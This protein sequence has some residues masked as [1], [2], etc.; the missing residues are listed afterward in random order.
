M[1]K[2]RINNNHNRKDKPMPMSMANPMPTLN[3]RSFLQATT[4][5]AMLPFF[6]AG[7]MVLAQDAASIIIRAE[8]DL[9]S[10]DPANPVGVIDGVIIKAVCQ[11][12]ATFKPN[13]LDYEPDAAKSLTQVSDTEIAFELNPG[14]M[15]SGGY[16][17]MTAEDVKFSLERYITPAADG[18]LPTAAGDFSAIDHVE[19]TGTYTGRI[20]L[21]NAAP[22]LW[23]VGLCD[24]GGAILSRKAVEALGKDIAT[25]IVGTGPYELTDWQPGQQIVLDQRADFAGIAKGA[26]Q[27]IV[28]KPIVETRTALLSLLAGEI[29][30]TEVA[31]QDEA[32]LMSS[33]SVVAVKSS[34]IDYTWIGMNVEKPALSD[35][36]VREALRLGID[37]DTLL[38]GA[39]GGAE[40]RANALLAPGLIGHWADAPVHARDLDKARALLAE[41]GQSALTITFTY[42]K[43]STNEAIAQIVQAN[44]AEIGV[45]VT[46]NGMEQAVYYGLGDADADKV[47][48]LT[49]ITFSGKNDP[50][51]QTQWFT[52]AQVSTWNWQRWANPE[53]DQLDAEARTI[54]D[55]AVRAGK[56]VR[57]QQ[58]MDESAAYIWITNGTFLYGHAKGVKPASLPG[59]PSWQLRH[60]AIA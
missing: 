50:G 31:T 54:L 14:Q 9:G 36:R 23:I 60:F 22:S 35:V 17:E 15:F 24:S 20:L 49:L 56:Y 19:V 5:A 37:V 11:T 42:L 51:F 41:A 3:R 7:S 6:G 58:I 44:L 16:G 21:K 39:Y 53:F 45:T 18:T 40:I 57:M 38:A 28:I 8:A 32:Q 1:R 26:F 52:G 29:A 30:L 34:R 46:L 13:S 55:P 25:K 27:K 47:L 10:L 33:D 43:D 2:A 4:G 48:D 59:G 12:L